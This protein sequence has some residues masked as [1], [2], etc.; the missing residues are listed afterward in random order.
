[1]STVVQLRGVRVGAGRVKIAASLTSAT[2]AELASEAGRVVAAGA[3]LAEWR[4]DYL[5]AADPDPALE[6]LPGRLRPHL[7]D[8][9][10]LAT[11]RSEVEGGQVRLTDAEYAAHTAALLRAGDVDAI[12]LELARRPVLAELAAEAAGAGIR[13]VVSQHHVTGTPPAAQIVEQLGQ[14]AQAGADIVKIAVTARGPQDVLELLTA[15]TRAAAELAVPV[16]TMAMGPAG[17]VSRLCGEVF[18][19]AVTFGAVDRASAPGQIDIG[20]LKDVV[21]I[22]HE[23]G[24]P[25]SRSQ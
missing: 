4:A 14:M 22:V 13:V 25:A 21:Q 8:L 19:S 16:I 9:P 23:H 1:M 17:L 20:Q 11:V 6:E 15:T 18:G 24:H 5:L 2:S 3:D 10:L 7:G 12:D